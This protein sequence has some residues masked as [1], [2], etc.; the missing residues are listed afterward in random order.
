[1]SC[2]KIASRVGTTRLPISFEGSRGQLTAGTQYVVA[3][4]LGHTRLVMVAATE[5][6]EPFGMELFAP[7]GIVARQRFGRG[8]ECLS[9]KSP[10]GVYRLAGKSDLGWTI[11]LTGTEPERLLTEARNAADKMAE[12]FRSEKRRS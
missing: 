5:R 10:R 1:M 3:D 6:H 8:S 4:H 9:T 11:D 2:W 12:R 7:G